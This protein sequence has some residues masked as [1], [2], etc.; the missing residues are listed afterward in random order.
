VLK[1]LFILFVLL[2]PTHALA[3]PSY[4]PY[5]PIMGYGYVS[6]PQE[7]LT[8]GQNPAAPASAH[9]DKGFTM[10]S[11]I[12]LNPSVGIEVGDIGQVQDEYD[13]I[14]SYDYANINAGNIDAI[15]ADTNALFSAFS[16]SFY[17]KNSAGTNIPFLPLIISSGHTGS[18]YL[19][20][21]F[22]TQ[23]RARYLDSPVQITGPNSI[24]ISGAVYAK[25]AYRGDLSLGYSQLLMETSVGDLYWGGKF[26]T[27]YIGTNKTLASASFDMTTETAT[28]STPPIGDFTTT[29]TSDIDLGVMLKAK[30]FQAGMSIT[31]LGSPRFPYPSIGQNCASI[32]DPA[33]QEACYIAVAHSDE[34]SLDEVHVMNPQVHVEGALLSSQETFVI[35]GSMDLNA[36]NDLVGDQVQYIT[37]SSAYTVRGWMGLVV[38]R[39]RM[40]IRKNLVGSG[41]TEMNVGITLFR[42]L[43]LDIAQSLNSTSFDGTAL[44]RSLRVNL[45]F[46]INL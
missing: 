3:A 2:S 45:G 17:V 14:S 11:A 44:P 16:D 22:T 46:G 9:G 25:A 37:L 6:L 26:N 30:R 35:A 39:F 4:L 23:T 1:R 42:I 31:N 19:S 24:D 12:S 13:A 33:E 20:A 15:V 29:T 18:Y 5:G 7:L 8:L 27:Y 38:P 21:D 41:L 36:I 34:I 10:H 43:S 28:T 40:G 32:S